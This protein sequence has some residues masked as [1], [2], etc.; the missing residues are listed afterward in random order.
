MTEPNWAE[1]DLAADVEAWTPTG[2]RTEWDTYPTVWGQPNRLGGRTGR[3]RIT[4]PMLNLGPHWATN[5][6]EDLT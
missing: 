3:N 4:S 6:L 5:R 1:P 2:Q